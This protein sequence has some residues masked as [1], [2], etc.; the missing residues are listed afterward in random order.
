VPEVAK[1]LWELVVTYAKQ[2]TVDPLKRLGKFIGFG[3]PAML[4]IGFGILLALI[5]LLRALQTETH[6]HFTGNLTWVPYAITAGVA[7]LLI[8]IAVLA[9]VRKKGSKA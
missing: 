4:L 8:A 3:M 1:E 7:V 9:I 6:S 5:G 2:E